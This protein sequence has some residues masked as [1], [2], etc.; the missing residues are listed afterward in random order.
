MERTNALD[1]HFDDL[2]LM[3][4]IS[5]SMP[6]LAP[7]PH[8]VRERVLD[9]FEQGLTRTFTFVSAAEGY[10]KTT[11]LLDWQARLE[12]RGIRTVWFTADRADA[13]PRRF[14]LNLLH[15]FKRTFEQGSVSFDI[16][17]W[18]N[19]DMN[20]FEF[21]W[22]FANEIC[23]TMPPGD[24]LV[25]IVECFDVLEGTPSQDQ[26][27]RFALAL[28]PSMHLYL[29]QRSRCS[30]YD[31]P[32]IVIVETPL[33]ISS[34]DL[35]YTAEEIGNAAKVALGR[36]IDDAA[37][38]LIIGKTAGWPFGV[39]CAFE[40]LDDPAEDH[41]RLR[42]FSGTSEKLWHF[43]N[44]E[45][46][47]PLSYEIRNFMLST[48]SL[49]V[50]TARLCDYMLDSGDSA[51]MLDYLCR[52]NLF[53][54][55]RD[56]RQKYFA[57]QPL[58]ADWLENRARE[59]PHR[60]ARLLNARASHWLI[61]HE[62]PIPAAHHQILA[63]ERED[64]L[65]LARVAFPK[66]RISEIDDAMHQRSLPKSTEDVPL[67]FCYLASWAYI[68]SADL[69]NA[70]YWLD[71]IRQRE[72]GESSSGKS[73]S[74]RV[75]E[76]K[77]A[78]LRNDF[79]AGLSLADETSDMLS[80]EDL[81]PLRILLTNCYAESFD[82]QGDLSRGMEYHRKI[83][84]ATEKY[85][86]GQ[87]ASINLYETAYSFFMQ[88]DLSAS[89]RVCQAI[90]ARYP[91]DFPSHT[92][93]RAL[94]A[95]IAVTC[96]ECD[97]QTE[98]LEAC[99]A[100]LSPHR[101]IDMYLDCSVACAWAHFAQ[102]DKAKAD[103]MLLE[104]IEFLTSRPLTVPRGQASLPFIDRAIMSLM[105]GKVDTARLIHEEF[106]LSGFAD[107]AYSSL[108]WRLVDWQCRAAETGAFDAAELELLL[109]E[110]ASRGFGKTTLAILIEL[111]IVR[112]SEGK[113]SKAFIA[114]GDALDMAVETQA[115]IPFICRAQ[116]I[117]PLLIA[118]LEAARPRHEQRAFIRKM[119]RRPDFS[120]EEQNGQNR[121]FVNADLS[122][123]SREQEVLNLA[124]TGLSRSEI[125][126]EMCI[127][128]S[129]VKTHLS[130][131]YSKFGVSRFS[132]LMMRAADLGLV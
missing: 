58:F 29:A 20:S 71:Q 98:E 130:H 96:G 79:A 3:P 101:N 84:A 59:I 107:T 61:R 47:L 93:A 45:V 22:S 131:L 91:A 19:E 69:R 44:Y 102:G 88:G 33:S 89:L 32:D 42:G 15:A 17:T 60:I 78:C 114:L 94:A 38:N 46:F 119:M 21:I 99:L 6:P 28:P 35:A 117:R 105:Q 123:T 30:K 85:E 23:E 1:P 10:G 5:K 51:S 63:C 8:V 24:S 113:R 57:Y 39:H 13:N 2:P 104:A 62:L 25:L 9:L 87:M 50:L 55:S 68:L 52:R 67:P 110:S 26:F 115:V 43:F 109:A 53:L 41:E 36:P 128:E 127:T 49:D 70:E 112:L 124:A 76:I 120:I 27:M 125:A 97:G 34:E 37:R 77:C 31:F 75:M 54:S 12:S 121:L 95:Y 14:W 106:S 7:S 100:L 65:N 103:L 90:E 108:I 83:E 73:L 48:A 66:L 40:L 116:A 11:A 82:Q 126:E 129:T 56:P 18:I 111:A 16:E 74:M 122:L 80:G 81:M 132:D 92:A 4:I 64:L 72:Q 86:F 118:Y